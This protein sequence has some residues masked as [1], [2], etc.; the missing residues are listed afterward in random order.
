LKKINILHIAP[1]YQVHGGGIFEVVENLSSVQ[2]EETNTSVD[3]LCLETFKGIKDLKKTT[4]NLLPSSIRQVRLIFLT[5]K[6]LFMK[7][8][9]YDVVHIHGAWSFQFFF[10]VPFFSKK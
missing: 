3:I 8:G 9:F 1:A 2:C 4:H 5:I 10:I 6:F 7:I